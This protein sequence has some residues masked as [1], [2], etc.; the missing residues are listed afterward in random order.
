MKKRKLDDPLGL[1]D[2]LLSSYPLSSR[3]YNC[4][5]VYLYSPAKFTY[6]FEVRAL[7]DK[8]I[9]KLKNCGRKTLMEIRSVLGP[10]REY[11][12]CEC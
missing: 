2:D 9:L 11:G 12:G 7:S 8:Q 10:P 4:L 1:P 3:A 6:G 5:T